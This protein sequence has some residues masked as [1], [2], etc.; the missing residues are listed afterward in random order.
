MNKF[1]FISILLIALASTACQSVPMQTNCDAKVWFGDVLKG[2][3][4]K[5]SDFRIN[6]NARP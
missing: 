3:P 6:C 4:I 1:L 2:K 5:D